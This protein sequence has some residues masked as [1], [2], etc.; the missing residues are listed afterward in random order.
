ML[1]RL[2]SGILVQL[3]QVLVCFNSWLRVAVLLTAISASIRAYGA[4]DAF[5]KE[6]YKRIDKYSR[7]A[8]TFYNLNR[9]AVAQVIF[10]FALTEET[11]DGSV[12]ELNRWAGCSQRALLRI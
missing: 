11:T 4:Q 12:C 6:S 10:G 9:Y 5:R 1:A 3:L 7:A 8:R 2:C